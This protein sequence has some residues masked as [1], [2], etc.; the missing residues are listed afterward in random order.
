VRTTYAVTSMKPDT[1]HD[2]QAVVTYY[3]KATWWDR[4]WGRTDSTSEETYIGSCTVWSLLTPHG[5]E[6]TPCTFWGYELQRALHDAW[7]YQ[8]WLLDKR[9]KRA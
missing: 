2:W 5:F 8:R 4:L 9:E 1:D 3:H 7:D 6:S